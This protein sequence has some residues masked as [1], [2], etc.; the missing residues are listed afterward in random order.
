MLIF[1]LKVL[2]LLKQHPPFQV[3]GQ[4]KL[5]NFLHRDPYIN[6]DVKV[7]SDGIFYKKEE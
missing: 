6:T 2:S 5:T 7:C 3:Q 1:T 4:I